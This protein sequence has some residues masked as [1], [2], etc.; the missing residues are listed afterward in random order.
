MKKF[1]LSLTLAAVGISMAAAKDYVLLGDGAPALTWTATE[2]GFQTTT[3]VDGATFTIATSQASSSTTLVEPA[4]SIRVYKYSELT[5]SSESIDMKQI[6][7]TAESSKYAG[8]QTVSEG[9]TQKVDGLNLTITSAGLKSMTMTASNNQYRVAGIVISD[10]V[11]GSSDPVNPDVPTVSVVNSIA[12]TVALS[13][14]SQ[15]TVNY[16]MVV[17]FVNNRNVFATDENGDFIQ[18]FG[19]NAYAANDVVPAGWMGTYKLY[20]GNTPE[21]IPEGDLP[22]ATEQK[23]FVPKVVAAADINTSLVNNVILVKN[24]EFS[25]DTPDSKSNFTGV[26]DGMEL[27]FRNNYYLASVPAGTY[28]VTL[29]VTIYQNAPSLYVVNYVQSSSSVEGI[30][31]ESDGVSYYNLQGVSVSNP[32]KGM[33]IRVEGNKATKVVF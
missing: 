17:A 32:D 2:S 16:P 31:V 5:I 8:E 28:D 20:S 11:S 7:L 30:S 3:T 4:T 19:D 21:I 6:V 10:E 12:E 15:V 27:S 13:S 9:W 25:E 33:Y 1:L 26:S 24:V 23:T 22:A 18:I 14:D 29:V